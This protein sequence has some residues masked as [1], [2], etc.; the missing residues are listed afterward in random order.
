M[1][2]QTAAT[3]STEEVHGLRGAQS[4]EGK[5][6]LSSELASLSF[7]SADGAVNLSNDDD[8]NRPSGSKYFPPDI[9]DKG[10][11]HLDLV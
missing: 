6:C 5:D 7:N 2:Y 4:E 10:Q 3:T 1:D 11:A 9:N 8:V